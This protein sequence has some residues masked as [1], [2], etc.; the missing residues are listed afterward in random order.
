MPVTIAAKTWRHA[1][2]EGIDFGGISI[3][4]EYVYPSDD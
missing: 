4:L 3:V 2:A 1:K